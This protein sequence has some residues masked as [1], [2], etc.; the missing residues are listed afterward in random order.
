MKLAT[1]WDEAKRWHMQKNASFILNLVLGCGLLM[2]AFSFYSDRQRV[3]LV[4]M[5]GGDE[6]WVEDG[7]ASVAYKERVALFFVERM[8]NTTP[9]MMEFRRVAIL[10]LISP[11]Y[12]GVFARQLRDEERELVKKSISTAFDPL[13]VQAISSSAVRVRG[14]LV[15]YVRGEEVSR[16][17]RSY[18]VEFSPKRHRVLISGF[19]REGRDDSN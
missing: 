12:H 18:L 6:E 3:I 7:Y 10:R 17:T 5:G 19:Y 8:M 1:F 16:D 11:D 13:S 2:F 4:P 15:S 9:S 14:A